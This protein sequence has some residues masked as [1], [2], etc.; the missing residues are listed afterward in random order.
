V[1]S[2]IECESLTVTG[3]VFFEGNVTIKGRSVITNSHKSRAVI[4]EGTVIDKDLKL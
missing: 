2:L 4:K 1:P 3:D